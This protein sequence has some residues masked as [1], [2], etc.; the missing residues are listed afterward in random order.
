M[1][2]DALTRERVRSLLAHSNRAFLTREDRE[3]LEALEAAFKNAPA[4]WCG[5]VGDVE[6]QKFPVYDALITDAIVAW[7]DTGRLVVTPHQ[8][9]A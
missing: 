6:A 4:R 9:G 1:P 7:R 5:V 2:D 8:E 3:T